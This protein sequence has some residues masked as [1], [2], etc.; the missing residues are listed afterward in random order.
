VIATMTKP[1]IVLLEKDAALRKT[2]RGALGAE[3]IRVLDALD[4]EDALH[5]IL[6]AAADLVIV[7][8]RPVGA[9]SS[10][11]VAQRIRRWNGSI[12]VI[13]VTPASSE[14]LA[15]AALRIGINDYF[16]HP[17]PLAE[18]TAST[19][20]CLAATPAA[21]PAR[22]REDPMTRML[23]SDPGIA[24]IRALIEQAASTDSN[25]L[26]TGETG[27]GKELTAELIHRSSRRSPKP[28]VRI[29]CAAIPDTLLESELFGYERGAFT[30]ALAASAGKLKAAD[31]GTVLFDEIGDLSVYAQA[32][33]LRV[34]ETKEIERLGARRSIPVDVRVIAATNQDLDGLMGAG[35]FRKDLYFRL[36]VARIHLP[37]LRERKG[38]LPV[39][40]DH[41]VREFGRTLG[42][43]VDGLT[44]DALAALLRHDW[45]GNVR[46]LRNVVEAVV[47][48]LRSRLIS[49]VDL[50]PSYRRR[51]GEAP[52]PVQDAERERLLAALS[53]T[54]W[55]KSKAAAQLRWSRMTVYRKLAKYRLLEGGRAGRDL[56]RPA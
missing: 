30:G 55:N 23:G 12:P 15:I 54:K 35:R 10:L 26:I 47:P 40:L 17:V 3:G 48:T 16:T 34:I 43:A 2:L 24:Q 51:P 46:E 4:E 36:N 9:A 21:G 45:P 14:Q 41:Y 5:A 22:G 20:R 29:N 31:G 19:R 25:V 28:L 39:L 49:L 13:L 42:R 38:D 7:G 27:T 6:A 53:A 56:P 8:A 37:P 18:L 32:K 1:A 11:D 50:P 52:A 44:D 33:I